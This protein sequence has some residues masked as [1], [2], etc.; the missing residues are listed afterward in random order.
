MAQSTSERCCELFIVATCVPLIALRISCIK[1]KNLL[2]FKKETEIKED[3][4]L[5]LH[6]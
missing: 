5:K 2:L 3:N 4:S 6:L 1:C